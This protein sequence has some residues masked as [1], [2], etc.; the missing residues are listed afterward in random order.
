[1]DGCA[2]WVAGGPL[3]MHSSGAGR[4]PHDLNTCNSP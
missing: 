3:E 1:V 2:S 4:A